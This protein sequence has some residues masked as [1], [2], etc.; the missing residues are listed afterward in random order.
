M[1]R[2]YPLIAALLGLAGWTLL[3][4][5][6]EAIILPSPN[7]VFRAGHGIFGELLVATGWTAAAALT[8]LGIG[9]LL[10][11]T[12]AVLFV[13]F[14]WLELALYPYAVVLQ[15]L[16]VI[17]IAPLLVIWLGYGLGVSCATAALVC[18]FPLLTSL[19]LGLTSTP[20]DGVALFQLQN[21]S[22][23]D[24]LLKLRIP[25]ALPYLFTGL[26]SGVGLAVIGAV[27]G[28]FVGSNGSPPS[29]GYLTMRKLRSA[30]TAEGFALIIASG[31]LALTLFLIVRLLERRVLS[32]WHTG[33]AS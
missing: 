14:R 17:A 1:K 4:Q 20:S 2:L 23:R 30:D 27:V 29:L 6:Y 33:G 7:E 9:L 11:C 21:A 31:L 28:E 24:M 13:R 26:R 10:A 16:P 25:Y 18:F 12:F 8:G 19:H 5:R 32:S 22:F 3:A 15:T